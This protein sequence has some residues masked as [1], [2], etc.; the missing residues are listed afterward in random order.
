MN[1]GVS[2]VR[3]F[4]KLSCI[5]LGSMV[6]SSRRPMAYSIMMS[7]S[8]P[9][10]SVI[11]FAIHGRI[12]F[13][14]T[15]RMSTC[16]ILYEYVFGIRGGCSCLFVKLG[17]KLHGLQEFLLLVA[18]ARVLLRRGT[19]EKSYILYQYLHRIRPFEAYIPASAIIRELET[20]RGSS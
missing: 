11:F 5:F 13:R 2:L 12:T 3:K 16:Y 18:E 17:R 20:R 7:S 15:L 10:S 8:K 1:S 9:M 19:F 6:G 4:V 14:L